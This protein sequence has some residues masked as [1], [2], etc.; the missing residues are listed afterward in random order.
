[1]TRSGQ[2]VVMVLS[3]L[4]GPGVGQASILEDVLLRIDQLHGA[5]RQA[6]GLQLAKRFATGAGIQVAAAT[7]ALPVHCLVFEAHAVNR[8]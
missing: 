7:P 1:M 5:G 6:L 4:S 3:C 2:L 8:W